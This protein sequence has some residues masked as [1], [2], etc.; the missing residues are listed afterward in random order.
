MT[1]ARRRMMV[2]DELREL[3][4]RRCPTWGLR[5]SRRRTRARW[6]GCYTSTAKTA[7]DR[8]PDV[9][10]ARRNGAGDSDARGEPGLPVIFLT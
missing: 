2:Q 7:A 1:G 9:G 3:Q 6:C 5:S 4:F 8:L 10:A